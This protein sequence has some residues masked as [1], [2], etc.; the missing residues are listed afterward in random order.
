MDPKSG[1]RTGPQQRVDFLA[2]SVLSAVGAWKK[3][4]LRWKSMARVKPIAYARMAWRVLC[5]GTQERSF[6]LL[7][8]V[9]RICS[10]LSLLGLLT[11]L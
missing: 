5:V 3:C 9:V 6:V 11:W 4:L 8:F 7:V 1:C 2:R 10:L